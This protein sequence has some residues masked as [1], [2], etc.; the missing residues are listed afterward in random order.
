M[1][2]CSRCGAE[3]VEGAAFCSSCGLPLAAPSD[4]LRE[5]RPDVPVLGAD[6]AATPEEGPSQAAPDSHRVR[7]AILI[8]AAVVVIAGV[9]ATATAL[10][11]SK[12]GSGP[13]AVPERPAVT[14]SQATTPQGPFAAVF[15]T[16]K[17]GVVRL[18]ASECGGAGVGTG[19]LIAPDQLA[20]VAHVVTGPAD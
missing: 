6:D 14:S 10:I 15:S 3:Q 9:A 17:T 2:Y 1:A 18:D 7:N 4:R 5:T 11:S 20:T 8:A 12:G 16:V 19:F 13:R